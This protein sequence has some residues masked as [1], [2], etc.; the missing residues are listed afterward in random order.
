MLKTLSCECRSWLCAR[1]EYKP[2]LQQCCGREFLLQHD[3]FLETSLKPLAEQ[4]TLHTDTKSH[5][6]TGYHITYKFRKYMSSEPQ[7]KWHFGRGH[8]LRNLHQGSCL[9]FIHQQLVTE[10]WALQ[11]WFVALCRQQPSTSL[12]P[13]NCNS[14]QVIQLGHHF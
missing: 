6:Q 13:L 7:G 4:H 3:S 11:W 8:K 9:Y 2:Q 12:C 14:N 5:H 1:Q 10:E